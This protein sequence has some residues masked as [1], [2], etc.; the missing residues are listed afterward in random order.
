MPSTPTDPGTDE[1]MMSL[2]EPA[3]TALRQL[4][5]AT[6]KG[7]K[8]TALLPLYHDGEN[9]VTG[10]LAGYDDTYWFI[11]QPHAVEKQAKPVLRPHLLRRDDVP[12]LEIHPER[13]YDQEPLKGE[14]DVL[15]IRFRTWLSR[16][17]FERK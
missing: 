14:M 6:I 11:L 13:T 3:M 2:R 15:I 7:Q 8:I 4:G 1:E 10:Y 12:H 5:R 16:N 9:S 17:V